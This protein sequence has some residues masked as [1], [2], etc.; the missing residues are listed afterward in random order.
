MTLTA[1][2]FSKIRTLKKWLDKSAKSPVSE[3]SSIS[4]MVNVP[5]NGLITLHITFIIFIDH[6]QVN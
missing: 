4:N 3:D 2:V 6:S 1:F 5:K